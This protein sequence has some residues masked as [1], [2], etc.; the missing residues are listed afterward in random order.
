MIEEIKQNRDVDLYDDGKPIRDM[1]HVDDVCD[2]IHLII[3]K[4]PINQ[5]YNV[6]SGNPTKIREVIEISKSILNSQSKINSINTPKFHKIVAPRDFYMKIDKL[7]S[8][9]FKQKISLQKG[10][11]QL[12]H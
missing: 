10:I 8:L 12:C 11:T 7:T 4:S 2:A 5:I 6:G 9:G 3:T 1:M